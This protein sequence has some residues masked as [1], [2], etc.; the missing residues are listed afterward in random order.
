MREGATVPRGGKKWQSGK[1]AEWQSGNVEEKGEI[2]EG[3]RADGQM[4][5]TR[6]DAA[7]VHLPVLGAPVER[8]CV[9]LAECGGR[10]KRPEEGG[11]ARETGHLSVADA[12]VMKGRVSED[13]WAA[14]M[15]CARARRSETVFPEFDRDVHVLY[16][17]GWE[18]GG[19]KWVAGI[20]FGIRAPA[21]VVWGVV[22]AAGVVTVVDERVEPGLILKSHIGAIM[23][24]K[25]P[26]PDWV[27]VDPAGNSRNDQTGESN[28]QVLRRAGLVVR[29]RRLRRHVGWE[30]LRARLRPA[31]GSAARLRVH[32]RCRKLIEAL[33]CYRFPPGR[34]WSDEP[35]KE[36]HEHAADALRY[37]VVNLERGVEGKAWNYLR[38]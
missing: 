17:D 15:L 4:A 34:P 32:C 35:M 11:V 26:R 8:D 29:D 9:L 22:D 1:V 28:V 5:D 10:A 2:A 31:D 23:S 6:G 7:L 20:D 19:L 38:G 30:M 3:Q 36:G 12:V 25:W 16:D 37:L 21:V 13:T 24:G 27:G 18:R 33:A 14:E